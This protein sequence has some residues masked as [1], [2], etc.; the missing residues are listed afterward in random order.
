MEWA[1][2]LD[3]DG[4]LIELAPSPDEIHVDEQLAHLIERL[5]AWTGGAVA[6]I[7]GRSI[8]DV[9]GIFPLKGMA[10][11]GQHGVEL[12][13]PDGRLSVHEAPLE[14]LQAVRTRLAKVIARHPRLLAEFKGVSVALHYRAAPRLAGYAHRLMRK[15]QSSFLSGYV[16]QA[17]K[18]VVELKPA[19]KDKG[20]AISE[21]MQEAPFAGRVPVF[22]GDDSTDELGFAVVNEMNGHS[23]KV[24]KGKSCATWRLEDVAAVRNWLSGAISDSEWFPVAAE[25]GGR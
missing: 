8:A 12:R 25:G 22:L 14:G 4:T 18:R 3:I 13:T 16:V 5:H 9:D 20:I 21:L 17:G 2:F 10:I 15:L 6:L 19:G 24:G 1:Y 23:I 7:T 11:A